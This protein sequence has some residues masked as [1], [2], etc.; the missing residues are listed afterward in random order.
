MTS[1]SNKD[2]LHCL[3]IN[4]DWKKK[5]DW[6]IGYAALQYAPWIIHPDLGMC[7]E[8]QSLNTEPKLS[9]APAVILQTFFEFL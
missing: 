9:T 4:T 6:T 1:S 8:L 7:I 3:Y 5:I 2:F